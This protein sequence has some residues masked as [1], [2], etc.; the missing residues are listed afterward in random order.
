MQ[1]YIEVKAAQVVGNIFKFDQHRYIYTLSILKQLICFK[2]RDFEAKIIDSHRPAD[3]NIEKP[4][5]K[6]ADYEVQSSP[7]PRTFDK[8]NSFEF[9]ILYNC[10]IL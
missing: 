1:E 9:C 3:I 2:F 6:N 4:V 10:R 7:S 8:V 5:E